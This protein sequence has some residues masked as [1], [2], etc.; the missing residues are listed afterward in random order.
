MDD[1]ADTLLSQHRKLRQKD[2][3]PVADVGYRINYGHYISA[4]FRLEVAFNPRTM[5]IR[6]LFIRGDW[7]GQGLGRTIV[8]Y[9]KRECGRLNCEAIELQGIL[10]ESVGFWEACGFS[11]NGSY[12]RWEIQEP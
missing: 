11:I 7:Q 4:P 5:I 10:S 3:L 2:C 12:G 9:L 8:E 1:F 6:T